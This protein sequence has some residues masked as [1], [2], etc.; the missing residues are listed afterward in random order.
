MR[1]E[2][3]TK[4]ITAEVKGFW[5]FTC[6]QVILQRT[7]LCY[8]VSGHCWKA[9]EESQRDLSKMMKDITQVIKCKRVVFLVLPQVLLIIYLRWKRSLKGKNKIPWNNNNNKK[10]GN[11]A[12]L[13][14]CGSLSLSLSHTTYKRMHTYF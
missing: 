14:L 8:Q 4:K 7:I 11:T 12:T 6:A 13:C 9:R 1:W 3:I 2:I 10:K 5:I